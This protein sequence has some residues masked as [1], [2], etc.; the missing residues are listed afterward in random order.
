MLLKHL[1]QLS[2]F[3][4]EV[5]IVLRHVLQFGQERRRFF[6]V[7]GGLAHEIVHSVPS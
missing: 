1:P 2:H 3:A 7:G 4:E 5:G 6:V